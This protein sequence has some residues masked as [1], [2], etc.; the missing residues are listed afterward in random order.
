MTRWPRA[1]PSPVR[2]RRCWA[3]SW[4][5]PVMRRPGRRRAR[6][7]VP[8]DYPGEG[9]PPRPTVP[10]Q[11]RC[12]QALVRPAEAE[13][14]ER[15]HTVGES[16]ESAQLSGVEQGDPAK[17]EPVGTRSEPDTLD[18]ARAGPEV[19]VGEGGT[20]EHA[21]RAG[22]PVTADHDTYRGFPD[23]FELQAAQMTRC[24]RRAAWP[25][26]GGVSSAVVVAIP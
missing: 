21:S 7:A 2:E 20:A 26:Q 8:Q 11:P 6:P 14:A 25:G 3:V 12:W 22:P 15:H 17:P 9:Q 19:G 23:P 4:A 13:P 16:E 10:L 5:D 24:L 18:R 1:G